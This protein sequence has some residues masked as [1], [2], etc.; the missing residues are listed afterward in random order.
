MMVASVLLAAWLAAGPTDPQPNG[1]VEFRWDAPTEQCPSEAEVLAQLERLLGGPVA[2]QGDRRLTAIARVRQEADGRWDLLLWTVTQEA[3]SQR[4][5][6]GADCVVLAEAAALLAAMAIDPSVLARGEASQAAVE[7]AEQAETVE[8]GGPV[9]E[10]EVVEPM[11]EPPAPEQIEPS[12]PTEPP[13]PEPS[14]SEPPPRPQRRF[15]V[16]AGANAGVSFGDL[17]GVG[18]ILRLGLAMQWPHARVELDGHYGFL[19][20]AR[21]EDG[22][23]VG[24]D[25][26]HGMVVARGC[27]VLHARAAKL[28]F[29]ICGGLEAGA[30]VGHGVGFTVIEDG[31]LP[32]LAVDVA[33]GL[34]W[35]PIPRLAVGL[36][37]EPWVAL[38]RGRFTA[39]QGATELWRPL[40]LGVRAVAGLEVRF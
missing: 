35:V 30:L 3:T 7:Q 25:L 40:P 29:P 38:V 16:A 13:Q 33:A 21:F 1:S 34:A 26:R 12:T 27:G 5:M 18:P 6:S 24:A 23:M 31:R 10:S 14:Q 20:R 15:I 11:A 39:E 17:P 9:P 19:R 8:G 4:S 28:E 36:R 2:E 32:W 22:E 37:V